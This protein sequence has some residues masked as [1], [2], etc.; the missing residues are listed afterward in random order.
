MSSMSPTVRPGLKLISDEALVARAA[1]DPVAE[2]ELVARY[3]PYVRYKIRVSGF[4]LSSNGDHHDILQ[5]GM[6]GIMKAVKDYQPDK[7]MSFRS[8]AELCIARQVITAVKTATRGKHRMLSESVDLLG[9]LPGNASDNPVMLHELIPGPASSQAYEVL[10][11]AEMM[12]QF[13][14]SVPLLTSLEAKV[15]S[16]ILNGLAYSEIGSQLGCNVKTVDNAM[17]RAK[18]KLRPVLEEFADVA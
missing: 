10:R 16:G 3:A 6:I 5:E 11:R 15:M 12:E 17:Q 7:G 8:F 1:T 14:R 18:R 13:Y 9:P 4:Y 2:N